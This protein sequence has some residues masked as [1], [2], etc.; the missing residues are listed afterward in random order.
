[1]PA[2]FC[3]VAGTIS[4]ST[5][6]ANRCGGPRQFNLYA[7]E[8]TVDFPATALPIQTEVATKNG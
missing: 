8:T 4:V 2:R 1:M 5:N 6:L 7:L 3:R